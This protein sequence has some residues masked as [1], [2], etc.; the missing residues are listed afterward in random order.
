MNIDIRKYIIN[1]FKGNEI[2][3]LEESINES[4]SENLEESLPG[5]GVFFEIIWNNSS[6]EIKKE[7]L[8][9]LKAHL[10]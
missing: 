5:M 6:N 4:I 10:N 8:E 2:K 3:E 1:N 9:I 7:L